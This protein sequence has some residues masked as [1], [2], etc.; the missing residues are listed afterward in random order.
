MTLLTLGQA[1]GAAA[2]K[3]ALRDSSLPPELPPGSTEIAAARVVDGALQVELPS[4][5]AIRVQL[6]ENTALFSTSYVESV[7]GVPLARPAGSA[8]HYH[9]DMSHPQSDAAQVHCAALSV[10]TGADG[11]RR[12]LGMVEDKRGATH[13]FESLEGTER[14]SVR[15]SLTSPSSAPRRQRQQLQQHA[16][17]HVVVP[18]APELEEAMGAMGSDEEGSAR[19]S[20]EGSPVTSAAASAPLPK[21]LYYEVLMVVDAPLY[22][23]LG[24]NATRASEAGAVVAN[25]V[26]SVYAS[27]EWG[28]G[29]TVTVVLSGQLFWS[30]DPA[31]AQLPDAGI[32]ADFEESLTAVNRWV[33]S[34]KGTLPVHDALVV[35]SGREFQGLTVGLAYLGGACEQLGGCLSLSW[36][37]NRCYKNGPCC[38][39]WGQA[40][41]EYNAEDINPANTAAHELGHLLGFVHDGEAG[42]EACGL[43]H[44]MMAA[45][46]DDTLELARFSACSIRTFR[47]NVAKAQD[48][49]NHWPY[50]CL[51]NNSTSNRLSTPAPNTKLSAAPAQGVATGFALV[52]LALALI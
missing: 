9:G 38:V 32:E 11:R 34:T 15:R 16:M 25:Q 45:I 30:T 51:K 22:A 4:L 39:Q 40:L 33:W 2:S 21:A 26:A 37:P 48:E 23:Q 28:D 5:G 44:T 24:S 35:L 13:Y 18:P 14:G 46:V 20:E 6:V 52:L 42:A 47:D 43:N 8:R 50:E 31:A 12:L 41:V 7:D 19:P 17:D 1:R 29:Y 3:A 27:T 49:Y 36:A 10:V